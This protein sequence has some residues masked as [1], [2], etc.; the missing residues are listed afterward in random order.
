MGTQ[1]LFDFVLIPNAAGKFEKE[2]NI[3]LLY[4]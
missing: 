2:K 4:F 1:D 3:V